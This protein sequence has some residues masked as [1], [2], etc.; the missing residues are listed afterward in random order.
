MRL[1]IA[2]A[3]EGISRGQTPF[4]AC[5]VKAGEVVACSHNEVW[6]STDITAHAEIV[7]IRNACRALKSIDLKGC[8]IYKFVKHFLLGNTGVVLWALLLGGIFLIIFELIH[9]EKFDAIDNIKSMPI[10]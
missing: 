8:V 9:R 3:K 6:I 10:L 2:K 7:A 1:A 4:G 5:I